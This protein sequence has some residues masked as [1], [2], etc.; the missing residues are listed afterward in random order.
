MD[1][2][3]AAKLIRHM[4]TEIPIVAMTADI[5]AHNKKSYEGYGIVDSIGKPYTSQ[6]LWRCLL[7]Y[8]EPASFADAHEGTK[9]DGHKLQA[10]L[11]AD[12]VEENQTMFYEIS[13]AIYG[14]DISLAHRLAH[15]LKSGAGLIGKLALQKAAADLEASLK[16][17]ERQLWAG[18]MSILRIELSAVLDELASDLEKKAPQ[19]RAGPASVG[20]R[21]GK[22]R[23]LIE[24]LEP[25]LKCGS[26]ESLKLAQGLHALPGAGELARLIEDFDFA[27]A[28]DALEELKMRLDVMQ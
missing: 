2:L 13:S 14:R 10:R 6:E 25:L 8:L 15:S 9:G 24:Q 12:F 4:G 28:I 3:Q 7:K 11:R 22:A 16:D 21:D 1:G 23:E 20:S 27:P 26:T 18:Q 5:K 17:G 19:R